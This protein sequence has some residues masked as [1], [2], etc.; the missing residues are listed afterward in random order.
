MTFYDMDYERTD[1]I[2]RRCVIKSR[3]QVETGPT[4]LSR[5]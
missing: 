1:D 4:W 2:D 3:D 5:I